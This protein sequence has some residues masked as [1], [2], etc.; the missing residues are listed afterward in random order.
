MSNV[1]TPQ[2]TPRASPR[3]TIVGAGTLGSEVCRLLARAG[4]DSVLVVDPDSLDLGNVSISPLFQDIFA[5]HGA[6][7]LASSK[8]HLIAQKAQT[9]YRLRWKSLP[10][11]IADVGL[12]L[13][14]QTDLILSCPDS[15]LARV[16]TAYAARILGIPMLDAGVQS[17]GITTGRTTWFSPHPDAACYLCGL[18]E[19]ARAEH[20]A[21]AASSSLGCRP[22]ENAPPMSAAP[23]TIAVVAQALLALLSSPPS[24]TSSTT[25]IHTHTPRGWQSQE[26]HLTRSRTCPW[27]ELPGGDWLPIEFDAPLQDAL[28]QPGICIDLLWPHCLQARCT[29]CNHHSHPHQR[30]A[31]VRRKAVCQNCGSH[32]TTDPTEILYTV[33]SGH[34]AALYTPRHLGFP[35]Q[36]LYHFRRT[37]SP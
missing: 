35:E 5:I 13:L 10:T 4:F 28:T 16:E 6:H 7:A 29:I 21:Y 8:A 23:Q 19:T 31:L 2:V 30:V 26:I 3:I 27:H 36:H 1:L 33:R 32:A 37:F 12:G 18:A 25:N 24:P 15:A 34:P 9:D 14:A 17:D 22:L 20:L 11:E